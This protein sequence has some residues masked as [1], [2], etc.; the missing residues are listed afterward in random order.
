MNIKPV[1]SNI[2]QTAL[3]YAKNIRLCSDFKRFKLGACIF[4]NKKVLVGGSNTNKTCP[5]QFKYNHFRH[6]DDVDYREVNACCHAEMAALI[7]LRRLYPKIDPS[8]LS[9]I[10]YRENA[11]GEPAMAKPCKACEQAL[12]DFGIRKIYYTGR[13]KLYGEYYFD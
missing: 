10:V 12:K 2:V 13:N 6:F 9:I 11:Q 5:S 4:N 8:S 7:R 1:D 3:R